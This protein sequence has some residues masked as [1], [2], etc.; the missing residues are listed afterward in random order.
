M[1]EKYNNGYF[2]LFRNW[3]QYLNYGAFFPN[4]Y[5]VLNGKVMELA[6]SLN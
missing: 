5:W 3:S 2:W 1:I 6:E 4:D